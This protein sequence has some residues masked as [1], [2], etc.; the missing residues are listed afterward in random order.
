MPNNTFDGIENMK[1]HDYTDMGGT[2]ETFLT[3]HWSLIE[4]VSSGDLDKNRA[5]L[6]LLLNKYWKPVYC[7]LRRKGYDNEKAKDLTQEFFYEAVFGRGLIQKA[8]E[9]KGRFRSFL[10]IALNRFL[11][12]I[13]Q[14]ETAQKRIPK[15]KLVPLDMVNSLEL[16][17]TVST[18]APE[19]SFNYAWV[20]SLLEDVLEEVEAKFHEDGKGV[21]WKVFYNRILQPI[22]D[23]INP[24]S[25]KEICER[26]EIKDDAKASNMIVT[27]KRRFQA[28]LKKQLRDSV[29]SEE[30]VSSELE[31]IKR[32]FPKF[33]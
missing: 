11:I 32:F 29:V 8:D 27:V 16:P 28:T 22:I 26:Y 15:D 4:D 33:A 21:H 1:P 23:G 31:E 30:Q 13:K 25:L 3:T 18:L 5:L 7:Y 17:Q 24:P 10:L 20:S 19:D 2:R 9:S 14:K 6:G 12:N